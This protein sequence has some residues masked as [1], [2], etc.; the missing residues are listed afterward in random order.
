MKTTLPIAAVFAFR[1]LGLFMLI[2]IFS[3][4]GMQL[5]HAT[6][7]L[8][9]LALGAYGFTQGMMQV[10]FGVLSDYFGRKPMLLIGLTL[11]G[12]G[13]MI[14]AYTHSIYGMILARTIQGFG[15]IGSVLIALLADLVPDNQRPKAMAII[16]MCIGLSFAIAM[17][18]SPMIVHIGGLPEIFKVTLGL[19]V[20]G[21]LLVLLVI[22]TPQ[23]QKPS[24]FHKGMI[25]NALTQP[26]LLRCHVGIW[27]QHFILTSSFFAIP[28]LLKSANISLS[29]FYLS[30]MVSAFIVML[31]LIGWSERKK[32]RLP[33]FQ[34][35]VILFA[36]AQMAMIFIPLE[37]HILWGTLFVYFVAF[38]ILEALFPSMIT[39]AAMPELRGTATGVYST[40]QFLGIFFGGSLS[41]IVYHQFST[42]GIFIMNTLLSL[43]YLCF[44]R[45]IC[46]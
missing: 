34:V 40:S 46:R 43:G 30:L 8:V 42:T 24:P 11:F 39:Q 4:Y 35:C 31:P 1:M 45:K 7:M 5:T 21:I 10:P 15:A 27:G 12:L 19:I 3:V 33:L 29:S 18:I 17:I 20:V 28:L 44:I 16:G 36:V 14:G 6:P 2:P 26:D 38:N 37:K 23:H 13:S 32:K 25:W 22:P 41:G 9:G